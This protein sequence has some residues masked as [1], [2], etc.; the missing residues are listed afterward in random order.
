MTELYEKILSE[1]KIAY[2]VFSSQYFVEEHSRY[3]VKLMERPVTRGVTVLWDLF[4]ELVGSE[5]QVEGVLQGKQRRFT[6]EKISKFTEQVKLRYYNLI[7][8]PFKK[9][10]VNQILCIMNDTTFETSLEQRIQQ[11]QHEI[12]LLESTL[13]S[14]IPPL[15]S[16]L[17]GDSPKIEVVHKFISKIADVK[18]TMILLEGETG[19]GKNLVARMIHNQ[20]ALAKSPF[21]EVNCASIPATL[22]ESEIFGYERGAFTNATSSKHG[23]LEEA[24]GG[25]FFLDE[26]SELPVALQSK[27]LSFLENKTFRRLGSTQERTVSVRIIAATNHNLLQA[28]ERGEFRQDL[29]FRLN[30]VS[31]R[32]PSLR[33]LGTDI[34]LIADHFIHIYAFDFK[35]KALRLSEAA[36]QKLLSYHWPGNVRELRNVIERAVIFAEGEEIE[37]DHIVLV[38]EPKMEALPA[39]RPLL[40]DAAT[41][42]YEME[43]GIILRALQQAKGNQTRAARSLGLTLDTLRYRIKKYRIHL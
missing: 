23:L 22:I 35:K 5:D 11:Q 24:D 41:S 16:G 15:S 28:V 40:P 43:K 10:G 25:T 13:T 37:P 2:A 12:K 19:T 21:V 32:L 30:V 42:L 20:S 31:L 18:S 29:F 34:I 33:E 8:L 6:L 1:K 9:S 4:P 27:F 38:E 7:L 3:F 17:I 14:A 39:E 26:I 36:Q